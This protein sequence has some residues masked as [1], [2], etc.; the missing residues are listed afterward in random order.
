MKNFGLVRIE[1]KRLTVEI[2]GCR[3]F[4]LVSLKITQNHI[5]KSLPWIEANSFFCGLVCLA[6][7]GLLK[8]AGLFDRARMLVSVSPDIPADSV[9]LDA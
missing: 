5:G 2:F 4:S 9:Q 3:P 7:P 8:P 6:E 1:R